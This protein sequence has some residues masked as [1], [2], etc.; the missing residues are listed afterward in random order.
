M[1]IDKKL[2]RPSK[3]VSLIADTSKARKAFNFKIETNLNELI[4][5]MMEN[6]LKQE[7]I[8]K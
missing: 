8:N 7:L 5:I 4:S 2:I 6:D 3:T 1:K